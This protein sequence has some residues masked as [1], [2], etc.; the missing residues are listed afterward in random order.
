MKKIK[1]IKEIYALAE[2]N[3]SKDNKFYDEKANILREK[4]ANKL[5]SFC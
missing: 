4:V 5:K 1:S 3:L 2:K